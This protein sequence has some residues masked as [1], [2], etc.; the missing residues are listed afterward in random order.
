MS[1]T[2]IQ[3]LAKLA[4]DNPEL[5]LE[6]TPLLRE[7]TQAGLPRQAAPHRLTQRDIKDAILNNH[8]ILNPIKADPDSDPRWVAAL[9]KQIDGL[10]KLLEQAELKRPIQAGMWQDVTGPPTTEIYENEIDHGYDQALGGGHD[11]MK[12]LQDQFLIEQG[13][14]PRDKNPRLASA[15]NFDEDSAGPEAIVES[16]SMDSENIELMSTRRASPQV[17]ASVE[18]QSSLIALLRSPHGRSLVKTAVMRYAAATDTTI[19][20]NA[21][22]EDIINNAVAVALDPQRMG[23]VIARHT[24]GE[25]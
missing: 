17:T 5:R 9:G 7:A 24:A 14:K 21:A 13:R 6:I 25:Q 4:L 12:R 20:L 10:R 11:V 1:M 8:A 22:V 19:V 18:L 2:P 16:D 3:K 23:Q 15:Y